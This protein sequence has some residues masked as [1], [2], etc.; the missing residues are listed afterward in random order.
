MKKSVEDVLALQKVDIRIR[1]LEIRYKTIPG[2]RA[3]LVS[4]FEKVKKEFAAASAAVKKLELQIRTCQSDNASEQEKL[5]ACKIRSGTIKK[6]AEYDAVLA[7]I[8]TCEKRISDLETD[9]L[10]LYDALEKARNE[11]KNAERQYKAVG[12]M[13]QKE[14][15]ELDQLK[16]KILNEIRERAVE[17]KTLEKNVAQVTLANYKRLLAAGQGDPVSPIVDQRI[18]GHCS[19]TLPPQTLNEAK[20]GN[21]L[22][23]GNCSFLIYDPEV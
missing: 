12:R 13:A 20:K 23:C 21:L 4:E 11:E 3:Q 17:A 22:E 6:A 16:E 1:N 15:R 9:E 10:E 5:Q 19:I 2:E 8:A 18:C 14:V 7:E